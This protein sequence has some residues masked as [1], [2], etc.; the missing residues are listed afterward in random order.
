MAEFSQHL[1]PAHKRNKKCNMQ[2]KGKEPKEYFKVW[3]VLTQAILILPIGKV[4]KASKCEFSIFLS[5]MNCSIW[6]QATGNNLG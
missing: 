2:R 3:E 4:W 6:Q 1:R 5:W